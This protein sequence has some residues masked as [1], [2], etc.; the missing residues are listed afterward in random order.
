MSAKEMLRIVAGRLSAKALMM[1]ASSPRAAA[2]PVQ[3]AAELKSALAVETDSA[4]A[5]LVTALQHSLPALVYLLRTGLDETAQAHA[6]FVLSHLHLQQSAL[7]TAHAVLTDCCSATAQ[8]L[9]GDSHYARHVAAQCLPRLLSTRQPHAIAGAASG[10]L[11]ALG[12][13]RRPD[14]RVAALRSLA[15]L[16]D[17]IKGATDGQFIG[18]AI[19]GSGRGMASLL[20]MMESNNQV[21]QEHALR[22]LRSIA[23][24]CL[25]DAAQAVSEVPGCLDLLVDV[26]IDGRSSALALQESAMRTLHSL[27]CSS[28]SALKAIAAV[29][30]CLSGMAALL[31][32]GSSAGLQRSAGG[33]LCVLS[34]HKRTASA[35]AAVPVF[36]PGLLDM[37]SCKQPGIAECGIAADLLRNIMAAP[38]G[39]PAV[40]QV[41]EGGSSKQQVS[42]AAALRCAVKDKR[43]AKLMWSD[44]QLPAVL[45]R[46]LQ[47][48]N[49]SVVVAATAAMREIWKDKYAVPV[50]AAVPGVLSTLR[51]VLDSSSAELQGEAAHTLAQLCNCAGVAG[52][53][54]S[55][56]SYPTKILQ[57]LSSSKPCMQC[58][59]AAALCHLWPFLGT[60]AVP[61]VSRLV[62][63]LSSPDEKVPQ[64]AGQALI[65]L[66]V[67]DHAQAA[68]LG[69]D[70]ACLGGLTLMMKEERSTG[71]QDTA[72][73][74]L[75]ALACGNSAAQ[76]AIAATPN[77]LHRLIMLLSSPS[78]LVKMAAAG[79]LGTVTRDHKEVQWLAGKVN[80]CIARLTN[81]L[82][83]DNTKVVR[84]AVTALVALTQSGENA[85]VVLSA[86]CQEQLLR[87]GQM[88]QDR[89]VRVLAALPLPHEQREQVHAYPQ[90]LCG[91]PQAN[92][93][94]VTMGVWGEPPATRS[95]AF[96]NVAM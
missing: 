81:M 7:S 13:S 23:T 26:A 68:V 24:R 55:V 36:M 51:S 64:W 67:H 73:C 71:V 70:S 84:S 50:L 75:D 15:S 1:T 85:G 69:T 91:L 34:C 6:A 38:A 17:S 27:A 33:I 16:G 9:L 89:A 86:R 45:I 87:V 77:C 66:T 46:F 42:A 3:A 94:D 56:P 90:Q 22:A 4:I 49:N 20:C 54:A 44:E 29:P 37:I 80:W 59:A 28:R 43:A 95:T 10:L 5:E 8:L 79:A 58:G 83:S 2:D 92:M 39:M 53:L 62:E 57:M 76:A 60:G 11:K 63:L 47:D 72:A 14:M 74:M 12:S 32:R 78:D 31:L 35:L 40:L 88:S 61:G 19:R 30:G 82:V 21:L 52:N 65:A 48:S 96:I 25:P 93:A 18:A 41:M